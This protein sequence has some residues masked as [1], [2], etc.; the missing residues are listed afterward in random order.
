MEHTWFLPIPVSVNASNRFGRGRVYK[1]KVHQG[2]VRHATIAIRM[3][4]HVRF[5]QDAKLEFSMSIHPGPKGN[6]GW[7]ANRDLDNTLKSL[8]DLF[9][10]MNIIPDDN[11]KTIVKKTV[12]IGEQAD[13]PH[14]RVTFRA[15]PHGARCVN[16]ERNTFAYFKRLARTF[17][18]ASHQGRL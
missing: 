2:W 1:S 18:A 12:S 3:Q 17:Q 8:L 10:R 16:Q 11:S 13:S 14:A 5:P 7:R 6:K 15:V 9:V 4:D